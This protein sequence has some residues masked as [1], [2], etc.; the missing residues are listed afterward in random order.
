MQKFIG[1]GKDEKRFVFKGIST[2][3]SKNPDKAT[4]TES[5]PDNDQSENSEMAGLDT[6]N[7]TATLVQDENV[8]ILAKTLEP[9][10]NITTCIYYIKLGD[11]PGKFDP[12]K[13][14]ALGEYN[15]I[16]E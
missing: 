13:A 4:I 1:K 12:Q 3:S 10:D 11:T 5:N 6:I 8:T 15:T 2:H 7:K 16:D 14:A 9:V